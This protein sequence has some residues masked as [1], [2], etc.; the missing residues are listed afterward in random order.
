MPNF[1]ASVL[2]LLGLTL[3]TVGAWLASTSAGLVATGV[4]VALLAYLGA[5]E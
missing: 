1:I 4:S 2:I 3:A 5:D